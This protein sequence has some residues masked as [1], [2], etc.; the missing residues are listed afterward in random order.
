MHLF[1]LQEQKKE[2]QQLSKTELEAICLRF[3]RFKK[4]NKEL[5]EFVLFHQGDPQAYADALKK[6]LHEV[7]TSLTGANYADAKK[8]RKITKALNK[9]A[10]YIQNPA[11]EADLWI[12]F[13]YT[14]CHSMAAKSTAQ[15][16]RN[17][18]AKAVLK[19]EKI[20]SKLHEDLAFDVAQEL[21]KIGQL[22]GKSLHWYAN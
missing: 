11:L 6:D 9:H 5:L 12:W 13:C 14:Y 4:E 10:K 19:V 1:S 16:I 17:F 18:F 2:L 7:F 15:V 20:Q 8:L 21:E 22:A 3:A